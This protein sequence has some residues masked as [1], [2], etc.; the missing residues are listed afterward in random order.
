[1]GS[2]TSIYLVRLSLSQ[3][4]TYHC[5]IEDKSG[6]DE[7]GHVSHVPPLPGGVAAPFLPPVDNGLARLPLGAVVGAYLGVRHPALLLRFLVRLVHNVRML[8]LKK[9]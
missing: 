7:L 5:F 8:A 6:L 9:R 3:Y 4:P 1:M 2:Q